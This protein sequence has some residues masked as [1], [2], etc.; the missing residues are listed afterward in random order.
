[1]IFFGCGLVGS[2][3][4]DV[5]VVVEPAQLFDPKLDNFNKAGGSKAVRN[6]FLYDSTTELH[7]LRFS[8][9]K[10]IK[11]AAWDTESRFDQHRLLFFT[12]NVKTDIFNFSLK[13]LAY[14]GGSLFRCGDKN[15]GTPTNFSAAYRAVFYKL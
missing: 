5:G 2:D 13:H 6:F 7:P 11:L 10:T 14:D 3:V 12:G 4:I 8:K 1:M 9:T 15:W